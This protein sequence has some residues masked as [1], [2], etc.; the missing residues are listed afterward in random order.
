MVGFCDFAS[1]TLLSQNISTIA[2]LPARVA[3]HEAFEGRNLAFKITTAE[4]G[5]GRTGKSARS[6]GV[7]GCL[8]RPH[9]TKTCCAVCADTAGCP[10]AANIHPAADI[11]IT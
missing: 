5:I 8:V 11:R 10:E 9:L 4:V 7:V 1:C 3:P 6:R 2:I